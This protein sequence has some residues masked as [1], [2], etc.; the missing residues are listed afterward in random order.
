MN[1][2]NYGFV[3]NNITIN[4]NNFNKQSKN[5]YGQIKIN[6]EINFYLYIIKNNA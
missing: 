5:L 4:N 1:L 3:F 2:D 6:N